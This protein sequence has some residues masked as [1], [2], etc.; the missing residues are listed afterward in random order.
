MFIQLVYIL[1]PQPHQCN[2]N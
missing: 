1:G 2:C